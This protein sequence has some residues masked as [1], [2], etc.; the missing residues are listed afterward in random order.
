MKR[1]MDEGRFDEQLFQSQPVR[2]GDPVVFDKA[3]IPVQILRWKLCQNY[4]R[5]EGGSRLVGNSSG[6]NDGAS[7]LVIMSRESRRTW[8]GPLAVVRVGSSRSGSE[9]YGI[10][11]VPATK[12]C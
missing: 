4:H 6:L 7:A 1:A 8:L 10:G 9:Y 12:K 3:N 5:L 2:K 11:P